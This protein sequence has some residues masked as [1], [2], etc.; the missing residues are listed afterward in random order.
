MHSKA[1]ANQ[2]KVKLANAMRAEH[3]NRREGVAMLPSSLSC[4]RCRSRFC[5]L[6]WLLYTHKQVCLDASMCCSA[7]SERHDMHAM[8][9]P[10]TTAKAS[11]VT[12]WMVITAVV[13]PV[14][15][16]RSPGFACATPGQLGPTET[17]SAPPKAMKI[18]PMMDKAKHFAIGRLALAA[19]N[20]T[21]CKHVK[22]G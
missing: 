18:P 19:P 16:F 17:A 2:A 4:R 10:S 1:K 5:K 14:I 15:I 13:A 20:S 9:A 8:Y 11:L 6:L 7:I 22:G 3:G 12:T 21:A